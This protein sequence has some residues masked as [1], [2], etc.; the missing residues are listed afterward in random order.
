[1]FL[2]YA[3]DMVHSIDMFT[4]TTC[5]FANVVN[6]TS[7][8]L[9]DKMESFFLA[10]TLKYLFLV[11]DGASTERWS[12][13]HQPN[14]SAYVFSTEA[15]PFPLDVVVPLRE[16][17]CAGATSINV[18]QGTPRNRPA[19]EIYSV[20]GLD[21]VAGPLAEP[22][23]RI[24]QEKPPAP[25]KPI[26]GEGLIAS[27]LSSVLPRLSRAPTPPTT[28]AVALAVDAPKE[29]TSAVDTAVDA[30]DD[31]AGDTTVDCSIVECSVVDIPMG[32]PESPVADTP[33]DDVSGA[34]DAS[35][36]DASAAPT[37]PAPST[38]H[39]QDTGAPQS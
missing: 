26:V 13:L 12:P 25:K 18:P 1:M 24:H 28:T 31:T 16:A 33:V 6:M 35:V 34:V 38:E 36:S 14:A 10:E 15:H 20:G 3:A 5:G 22:Q 39:A 19:E 21:W 4:R 11:F 32:E 7:R 17:A 9:E 37:E 23:V 2:E 8:A 29:D 27:L 30:A